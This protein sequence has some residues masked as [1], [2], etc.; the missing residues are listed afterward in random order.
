MKTT[1]L[2]GIKYKINVAIVNRILNRN[3]AFLILILPDAIGRV[4][5]TGCNESESLS[6]MSFKI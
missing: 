1:A 3:N 2:K 6:R 5:F 4:F